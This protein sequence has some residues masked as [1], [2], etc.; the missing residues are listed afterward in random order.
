MHAPHLVVKLVEVAVAAQQRLLQLL[1]AQQLGRVDQQRRALVGHAAQELKQLQLA[2]VDAAVVVA[3]KHAAR[4][5]PA[6]ERAAARAPACQRVLVRAPVAAAKHACKE[7]SRA[8]V[9]ER[10]AGSAVTL[11]ACNADGPSC[12]ARTSHLLRKVTPWPMDLAM[13]RRGKFLRRGAF[14]A[15]GAA[16]RGSARQARACRCTCEREAPA[17]TATHST[18]ACNGAQHA[19]GALPLPSPVE[20][21]H[22]NLQHAVGVG[23]RLAAALCACGAGA[24]QGSGQVRA[25]DADAC[26]RA[27]WARACCVH[28]LFALRLAKKRQP[29]A[30]AAVTCHSG[31]RNKTAWCALLSGGVRQTAWHVVLWRR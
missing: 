2:L 19:A 8:Q 23:L 29:A 15:F 14:G 7:E 27:A 10:S 17:D 24:G 6:G 4:Q 30:G 11:C 12:I 3:A 20:G 1:Q 22:V 31:V 28:V 21:A 5:V 16:A 18:R 26:R 25:A 13:L 9:R